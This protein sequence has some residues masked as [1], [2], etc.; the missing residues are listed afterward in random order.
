MRILVIGAGGREHALA[1]KLAQSS[2]VTQIYCIP[3]NGGTA[4]MPKC[5]NVSLTLNDFEGM[6]R[7]AE[8]QGVSL[9]VIG[10]E[11]PLAQGI[12]DLFQQ[13]GL[14]V[15]GPTQQG[16]MI[17]SS[18]S[19]AKELMQSA[20]IPTAKFATFHDPTSA[21]A[22]LR[23]CSLPIV[24]KADGLAGGKGVTIAET[25]EVAIATI[26]SLFAGQLGTAGETV[27]IEDFLIG[28]ELSVLAVTDG[29]T[30]RPLLPARDRKRIGEGDTGA[31]TGGMGAFA[32]S[33]IVTPDLM[34]KIQSHILE[35]TIQALN[36]RGITYKGCL[37]AGLMID[38]Q[39]NPSVVEFNCRFGD[40]ETQAILPLLATPLES[41][42][43]ACVE[44]RLNQLPPMQWHDQASVCVILAAPGYPHKPET[45]QMISGI[46]KAESLGVTVFHSGTRLKNNQLLT[47]GGRVLSVTATGQNLTEAK[48]KAYQAV[49]HIYFDGMQYRK[50]IV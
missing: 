24:V 43:L 20:G 6:L 11:L 50:D 38:P 26:E 31:N 9:T 19:W 23:Q 10:P 7:F 2:E 22:Y 27:V 25:P 40:P 46:G 47:S 3:G 12:A 14:A 33:P 28:E 18:K 45:G 29:K 42:L 5:L 36:S 30:I 32:P 15:F 35:P 8:V 13:A 41:I 17:E 44:G 1:W 34:A 49:S 4:N 37:Y 48:E 39:G 16:A 21:I